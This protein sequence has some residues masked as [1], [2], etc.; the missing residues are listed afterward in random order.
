[1][2]GGAGKMFSIFLERSFPKR[3]TCFVKDRANGLFRIG[4]FDLSEHM[5]SLSQMLVEMDNKA[6]EDGRSESGVSWPDMPSSCGV[7]LAF[8]S[9][10]QHYAG[11]SSAA[12]NG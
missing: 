10:L 4:T 6:P 11:V 1:M 7:G 12:K 5:L 9:I 2:Y 8:G 3:D